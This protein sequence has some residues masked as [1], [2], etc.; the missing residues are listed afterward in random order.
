MSAPEPELTSMDNHAMEKKKRCLLNDPLSVPL[1]SVPSLSSPFPHTIETVIANET[2]IESKA[3]S[4]ASNGCGSALSSPAEGSPAKA[5][6]ICPSAV[7]GTLETS[8]A[9]SHTEPASNQMNCTGTSLINFSE[10]QQWTSALPSTSFGS[11]DVE[12]DFPSVLTFKG[13][14]VTL[15]NNSVWKQFYSCGTEMILTKQGRRMFPY[16]RYR[17]SG[18]DPEQ[19]YNLVLSI[20]P[21]GQYRYRWTTTKWEVMGPVEHQ[22]QGL[23]R[24]YP[25]HYS[26]CKGSEWMSCLVSFYKL[27]LT[28]NLQDRNGHIIL[29]SMHRYIPRLH[30]IPV[31]D[32]GGPTCDHPVVMGPESLIFTFP[33]TEFMAVTTYQNFRITQLKISHNPFAK[34]FREDGNNPRLNRVPTEGRST[35]EVQA[36][37]QPTAGEVTEACEQKEEVAHL[38]S[39][40]LR[41]LAPNTQHTRP[42]L[43]PIMSNP[44]GTGESYVPCIRGKHALGEL[45]LVQ[46]RPRVEPREANDTCVTPE[47]QLGSQARKL[48]AAR[49]GT[50]S[51]SASTPRLMPQYRKR[52][53]RM[54]KRYWGNS[55]GKLWKSAAAASPTVVH[56]PSLTVAMQPELDEVEGLLFVSFTS[57]EALEVHVRDKPGSSPLS[58]RP[59]CLPTPI[60]SEPIVE[61][62]PET[63]EE[64]MARLESVLLSDL[65]VL[66]H[67][68]IIHPVLQEVGLKLSSLDPTVPIDL[69]YLGVILPPPNP[70]EQSKTAHA[71]ESVPFIS[72]TGKTSDMTKIKGWKNKF[73]KSKESSTKCEGLQKNLS[74][75][76]SNMLDEY[77]ESE[78]QQISERA[79]AFCTN[80]EGSVAYQLPAKSSSYV[81]TLDSILK[82]QNTASKL[83]AGTT[84][85]CPR[86]HKPTLS[87]GM[88]SPATSQVETQSRCKPTS[89]Q[90]LHPDAANDGS[91]RPSH[92]LPG[93]NKVQLKLLHTEMEALNRGLSRT[94][95]TPERITMALSAVVSKEMLPGQISKAAPAA[96]NE[97]Q[98]PECEKAFCWLGCVCPSLQQPRRQPLHCRRPE[99]MFG[100]ACFKR[101]TTEEMNAGGGGSEDQSCTVYS[102]KNMGHTGCGKKLWTSNSCN[103][104][105]EPL[106]IPKASKSMGKVNM[107]LTAQKPQ[108]QAMPSPAKVVTM[109]EEE[110]DPV[111]LYFESKLTCA[112][113]REFNSK[114]PPEVTLDTNTSALIY[115]SNNT[116]PRKAAPNQHHKLTTGQKAE[117]SSKKVEINEAEA[118]KQIQ[119]QSMCPWRKDRQMVLKGLCERMK[120]NRLH[121]HSYIGP[122]CIIPV[123]KVA[124]RKPSGS[125]VTYRIQIT[126]PSKVSDEEEESDEEKHTSKGSDENSDSAEEDEPVK[127]PDR[128]FGV[129]PFLCGV[130]PAGRLRARRKHVGRQASGLIQVNG[131]YYNHAR[132]LLGSMGSLHPANRLAAYVT[133]RLHGQSSTLHKLMRKQD[134]TLK[135]DASGSSC[136]KAADT[137]VPPKKT[138][139]S[140]TVTQPSAHPVQPGLWGSGSLSSTEYSLAEALVPVRNGSAIQ[141]SSRSSPIRLTVSPSLKSPSFLAQSGTCSFRICPPSSHEGSEKPQGVALPGGFTLIQ[142]PQAGAHSSDAHHPKPQKVTKAAEKGRASNLRQ[143]ASEWFGG[144]SFNKVKILLSSKTDEPGQSF[145]LICEEKNKPL[146]ENGANNWQAV[147]QEKTSPDGTSE[148]MS[149]DFSDDGEGGEDGDM[150][151]IETVEETEQEMAISKLKEA[152][153]KTQ[154]ETRSPG[155]DVGPSMELKVKT[156]STKIRSNHTELE[157]RRRSEQRMLFDQLRQMLDSDPKTPK[158]LLLHQAVNEIQN[159]E[160][161]SERMEEEKKQ[162]MEKQAASVKQLSLLAGKPED[163]ILGKLKAI[164]EK[165]KM[166]QRTMTWTPVFSQ[167]L[168]TKAVLLQ[169]TA[170]SLHLNPPSLPQPAHG[171]LSEAQTSTAAQKNL[172]NLFS[173][174]HSSKS[175]RSLPDKHPAASCPPQAVA[176]VTPQAEL[177]RNEP[178]ASFQISCPASNQ[179]KTEPG[180]PDRLSIKATFERAAPQ[181]AQKGALPS[182][183]RSGHR[184]LSPK[185]LASLPLVRSKTGRIILPSSLK[186]FNQGFY[187]LMV[188][189]PREKEK[190][191]VSSSADTKAS[192]TDSPK[193]SEE[194]VATANQPSES[195]PGRALEQSAAPSDPDPKLAGVFSPLRQLA[196]LNKSIVVP[197]PDLR[198]EEKNEGAGKGESENNGQPSAPVSSDSVRWAVRPEALQSHRSRKWPFAN[199]PAGAAEPRPHVGETPSPAEGARGDK[200]PQ[201]DT[202]M[203][204]ATNPAPVKSRRGRP[205]KRGSLLPQSP[206]AKRGATRPSDSFSPGRLTACPDGENA[207]ADAGW[208]RPLTRGSLG[209]DFPSAKKRSWIDIERQLEPDPD[210]E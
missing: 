127:D 134:P 59:V 106:F 125:L 89:P 149:S 138:A 185:P 204:A 75:F 105:L 187:T 9:T 111:Y 91:Q 97:V 72:R 136:G 44:T 78:A 112:R 66:K 139:D 175:Q 30:I 173:L 60:K 146:G 178:A 92:R 128:P 96:V 197:S 68:Q 207:T 132:L 83:T 116:T 53:R 123:A 118:R 109:Q 200:I 88:L 148:D 10:S 85:P 55:R 51:S 21:T 126:Q 61:A 145:G 142:L 201:T 84:R 23:I 183:N 2:V 154:Q 157:R 179:E 50:P 194:N 167:L 4:M 121:Q 129:T 15:E 171:H 93:F 32:G 203:C 147:K 162:L 62:N 172:Q 168:Q 160:K 82:H 114:P 208:S 115:S 49:S 110:K 90:R 57:K 6:V 158:F 181:M 35:S 31:P 113:V 52:K 166:L 119:I 195:E 174:F 38:S 45:V 73:I 191:G 47:E 80:P 37:S 150:V 48:L 189:N 100:C 163:L 24:A 131:K 5:A 95:L 17:L 108:K 42:V 18:L 122:Y 164:N 58:A 209:K 25:H 41:D 86:S 176:T 143:L 65:R 20:V 188:M 153:L 170:P 159:L 76:C 87:S 39:K 151:D 77:L 22:T 205:P 46:K 133:G 161:T 196:L 137:L 29:H 152:A 16:C 14:S 69:Q 36:E 180:C 103:D 182:S 198:V 43:K 3:V 156:E 27:K 34:G 140:W 64:K 33:Q 165:Q 169:A 70:P 141:S 120:Q 186:P 1:T 71:D 102:T 79:A 206:P 94:H 192:D 199:P 8:P 124:M 193:C 7:E 19:K 101:Q 12:N 135:G 67:R 56:S 74:A 13:I 81:K 190:S 202:K 155:Y 98:G 144:D 104:D 117:K 40:S 99:C 130:A 63:A 107:S 54:K 184:V 26:P 11:A 28:N 210:S 177:L